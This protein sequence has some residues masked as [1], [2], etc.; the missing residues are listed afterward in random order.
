[1]LLG[2]GLTPEQ[3]EQQLGLEVTQSGATIGAEASRLLADLDERTPDG[4]LSE[5]SVP[6]GRHRGPRQR[7]GE[8]A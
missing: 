3:A 5:Q 4:R 2:R 7:R 6:A 8:F 1:M